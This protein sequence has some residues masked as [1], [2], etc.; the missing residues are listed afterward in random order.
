MSEEQSLIEWVR[1]CDGLVGLVFADIV[2]STY[3][4]FEVGTGAY[5]LRRQMCFSRAERVARRHRGRLVDRTGDQI[6]YAFQNARD[7]MDFA[8]HLFWSRGDHPAD[9]LR[10]RIGVHYGPVTVR[11]TELVGR[12]VPYTARV[13]QHGLGA[14]LWVSQQAKTALESEGVSEVR[15][16][17]SEECDLPGIPD[18]QLLWRAG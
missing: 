12:S 15:W 13:M 16:L 8:G 11:G 17:R 1:R 3:I 10:L 7:S 6:F 5:E 9:L 18:K 4:L 14:E 2:S